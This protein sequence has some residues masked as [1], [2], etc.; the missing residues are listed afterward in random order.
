MG[1]TYTSR[2]A[3]QNTL[4]M[5]YRI[6]PEDRKSDWNLTITSLSGEVVYF[7]YADTYGDLFGT[8]KAASEMAKKI[9]ERGV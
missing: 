5:I 3:K 6:N 7:D 2:N 9:L 8:K 4:T 1:R